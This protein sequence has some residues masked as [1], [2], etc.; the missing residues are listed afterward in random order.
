[1][2]LLGTRRRANSGLGIL[3]GQLN[4]GNTVNASINGATVATTLTGYTAGTVTSDSNT[5]RANTVMNDASSTISGN[6]PVTTFSGHHQRQREHQLYDAA[7]TPRHV[8]TTPATSASA[9]RRSTRAR[10]ARARR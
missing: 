3:S 10:P 4:N 9:T 2:S 5:I 1:M 6:L 8:A 7:P